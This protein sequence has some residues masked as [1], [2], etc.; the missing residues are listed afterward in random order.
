[1][2]KMPKAGPEMFTSWKINNRRLAIFIFITLAVSIGFSGCSIPV[3]SIFW[4]E[5]NDGFIQFRTN[6]SDYYYYYFYTWYE[7]SYQPI[8][9]E[10]ETKVKK[11][12]GYEWGGF[13]IVF[14]LQD[15]YNFYL[16]LI[17]I[18]GWYTIYELNGGSW[19]EHVAWTES[20]MLNKGFGKINTLKIEHDDS[21]NLFTVSFNGTYV[22][23]FYDSSFNGGY[24]GYFV[25]IRGEGEEHFPDTPVDVRFKQFLAPV[26]AADKEPDGPVFVGDT[27]YFDAAGSYDPEGA[28]VSYAWDFG[29]GYTGSGISANHIYTTEGEYDVTLTVADDTGLTDS[30][31]ITVTV[32]E[33]PVATISISGTIRKMISD[34]FQEY[35]YA[36]DDNNSLMFINIDTYE[37][38]KSINI[39]SNPTDLDIDDSGNYLYVANFGANEIAVVDLNTKEKTSSIATN[40]SPYVVECG[41]PGRIYYE[42]EDQWIYLHI[43]NSEQAEEIGTYGYLREGDGEIDPT[44]NIYYHCENNISSSAVQKFDISTDAPSLITESR[45]PAYGSRN[46]LLSKDGNRVFCKGYMFDQDLNFLGSFGE[47]YAITSDGSIASSFDTIYHT[48]TL[49]VIK[50]LPLTASVQTISNDDNRLFLY[51]SDSS[52]IYVYE[53]Q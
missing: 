6:E 37:L 48:P 22:N 5:D 17:D 4:E 9:G 7:E 23:S 20:D 40:A 3:K 16:L 13:G 29:D 35:I 10:I 46:L 31:T 12:S 30:D 25:E 53:L 39:G 38:E 36:I 19:M 49:S 18:K 2:K 34:P 33:K 11:V 27:V 42:E 50:Q 44:G 52:N 14:C 24:S 28:I 26:A 41:R 47:I 45:I 1:M 8:L 32:I 21:S 51:D 15:E 43:I